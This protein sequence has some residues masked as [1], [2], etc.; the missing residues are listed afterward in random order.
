ML[1][2]MGVLMIMGVISAGGALGFTKMMS[3][4]K[5]NQSIQQI[6]IISAKLSAVGSQAGSYAG[7][8]NSSAIKYN[9][10][11]A[12]VNGSE[13]KNPFGGQ[14]VIEPSYLLQDKSDLQAYTITYTDL[15][16][17]ACIAIAAHDWSGK[18][19]SALLG[20]GTSGSSSFKS[21]IIESIYQ[22][23]SNKEAA[24][25]HSTVCLNGAT[26]VMGMDMAARGCDCRSDDCII[27]FKF[28]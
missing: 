1:E 21:S 25:Q 17:D 4:H 9:A 20:L 23:C 7:L 11:P 2:M 26:S 27:V 19:N 24:N 8:S 3:Q 13:I 5:I 18:Q 14:I 15:P 22:G 16:P 12:L 28:F 10:V 6:N